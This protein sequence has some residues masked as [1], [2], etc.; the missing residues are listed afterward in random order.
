MAKDIRIIPASGQVNVTGSADF[1]GTGNTSVLYVSGSGRVGVG[2]TD[3]SDPLHV[4]GTFRATSVTGNRIGNGTDISKA[5]SILDTGM[6][7]GD[8]NIVSLGRNA[9]NNN[10]AEITFHLAQTGSTSNRLQLGLY[11]SNNTLNI[12]GSGH[13]GIG[14]VS[15][16]WTLTVDSGD[17]NQIARFKSNDANSVISV[18]DSDDIAFFGTQGN[19]SYF[20]PTNGLHTSNVNV[21]SIG[22]VGI[23]VTTPVAMLHIN[24][25]TYPQLLLDGGSDSTGDIVVPSGE[26]LQVGHWNTSTNTYTGRFRITTAGQIG[27]DTYGSGTF[28]GTAAYNLAID[29]SGNII[30]TSGASVD[31][32]GASNYFSR[33]VDSNTLT[34]S[35]MY[36][37]GANVGIGVTSTTA[38]LHVSGT[39]DVLL[40][41]GSGSTLVD[42]QGSQGQLFSVTDSLEGSLFSVNDIS[43]LPILEVF[44]TDKMVAGT[45]GQNTLVVTGSSV[46]I[47]TSSPT[48]TLDVAGDV[49]VNTNKIKFGHGSRFI[50]LSGGNEKIS[51]FNDLRFHLWDG[52]GYNEKVRFTQ[53][54]N[55]GIGTSSPSVQLD[56]EDSGNVI[57]DLNTTTANANTTIRFQESG[58]VK[59]TM[60]YEGSSD[61][62]LIANGGFTAGNGINIDASNNVGIG[63]DTPQS[64]LEVSNA[65]PEI[66]F[67]DTGAGDRG[68]IHFQDG[69][70]EI[71]TN[72]TTVGKASVNGTQVVTIEKGGNVGIGTT[73]PAFQLDV[74]EPITNVVAKFKSG[75]NQAWIS[76]QDDTSGTYGAIFGTDTDAG[77]H[78]VLADNSANKRLVINGDGHVGIGTDSPSKRLHINGSTANFVALFESTDT[79][80]GINLADNTTSTDGVALY[81]VGDNFG[82]RTGQTD[83]RLYITGSSGY[84]G[85]GTTAPARALSVNSGTTNIVASF[86]STDAN[87]GI[88]FVDNSTSADSAVQIRAAG[89]D[90][91]LVA[92]SNERLRVKSD[93]QVRLYQYGSGNFT[94]NSVYRLAVDADGNIIE[95][96]LGDGSINGLGASRYFARWSDTDSL[97]TSS[98]YEQEDGNVGLGTTAPNSL[99]DVRGQVNIDG[100]HLEFNASGYS[101]R[102]RHDG[103]RDLYQVLHNGTPQMYL[104]AVDT[105]DLQWE[106]VNTDPILKLTQ[107][108]NA[109]FYGSV[110]VGTTSPEGPLDIYAAASNANAYIRSNTGNAYLHLDSGLD[111]DSREESGII[112]SD[113]GSAHWAIYKDSGDDFSIYDYTGGY[114]AFEIFDNGRMDLMPGANKDVT[115]V[116][117]GGD[118]GIGT[119][120]PSAKLHVV[121]SS[122]STDM[123]LRVTNNSNTPVMLARNDGFVSINHSNFDYTLDVQKFTNEND[124]TIINIRSNWANTSADKRIGSLFFTA[125]DVDVDSGATKTAGGIRVYAENEWTSAANSNAYMTLNTLSGGSFGERMRITSGGSVGIGTTSPVDKL[126][127]KGGGLILSKDG[128]FRTGVSNGTG[129]QLWLTTQDDDGDLAKRIV[130]TGNSDT[131][132]E[133]K[134]K[135]IFQ[136]KYLLPNV[137]AWDFIYRDS[138]NSESSSLKV[139]NTKSADILFNYQDRENK[140]YHI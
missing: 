108:K 28:T 85:I 37:D 92:G 47:G 119:T 64:I 129:A 46:G 103:T 16:S 50:N 86:T 120:N 132:F 72:T 65:S 3:P 118:V 95:E 49:E 123:A 94:A 80:G 78:V 122:T 139:Y 75:D 22:R 133:Q 66:G 79:K 126:H 99:L 29:S 20:G 73:N 111:G 137:L 67:H 62:V 127:V 115:L 23:G 114:K 84:V 59:A 52:V 135:I 63:T 12:L 8:T 117:G 88:S 97:T 1:K 5:L 24:N 77:H 124:D 100:G 134:N 76:V 33:W 45:F 32:L 68:S 60:G 6:T 128:S 69:K 54:G 13:V 105:D 42:I 9:A 82:I 53:E 96:S 90:L 140:K 31:G 116:T 91:N 89:D 41:E 71:Y 93:G 38:T 43:G 113:S 11:N 106:D 18:E 19:I 102:F 58:T 30:E 110:G 81:A 35:S 56:I 87:A 14:T 27:L 25:F 26:I 15:P 138:T 7:A 74:Y 34:S 136:E 36:Q 112:F 101:L 2:T 109:Y 125:R 10:Q 39:N 21:D 48:D 57:A 4:D 40:V 17:T 107:E 55:V 83:D 131:T 98:M 121:G 61:V 51:T 70:F 130:I 44:D 104:R